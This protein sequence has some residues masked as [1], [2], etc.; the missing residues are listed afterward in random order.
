VRR[1][2]DAHAVLARLLD[3]HERGS[4]GRR[5][6]ER[7]AQT[8]SDPASRDEM[9]GLLRS[10]EEAGCVRLEM[11]RDAP[12]LISRVILRDATRLYAFAGRTPTEDL[13]RQAADAVGRLR[14]SHP[15]ASR[16]AREFGDAWRSGGRL[17]GIGHDDL[18]GA[19]A[20]VAAADAALAEMPPDVPLRTRSA[21]LLGDSKALERALG[22]L[23]TYMRE[24]G[25]V[26]PDL[27]REEALA[28]L[29]LAKFLQPVLACGPFVVGGADVGAWPY[30]GIPP[31]LAG[32]VE[33]SGP[34]RSILT[35][36][37]LESFNRHARACR[38]PGDVVVYSGGFPS[39]AVMATLR[40]V[41]A[42]ASATIMHHWGDV[43]PGGVRIGRHMETSLGIEIR[44][45]LMEVPTA[46]RLGTRATE[47]GRPPRLPEG[48]SF[49]GLADYLR[50]PDALWLEQEVVDPEPV[51][52]GLQV[53]RPSRS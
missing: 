39:S 4:G 19:S 45:H 17:V 25:V 35:I 21:R 2:V 53:G 13:V 1:E 3:R 47:P 22:P 7:P 31:E 27:D 14:P 5:I 42:E 43:D 20:L 29:G 51:P 8:F 15:V 50:T 49:S 18:E 37:N 46:V 38:L 52:Q 40:R 6:I 26:D 16:L 48:S 12:H 24:V 23:L 11:D 32:M 9:T 36:E 28:S 34:V 30:V 44:P 41:V 10:A 33:L